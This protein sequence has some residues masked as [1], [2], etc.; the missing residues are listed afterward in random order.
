[1]KAWYSVATNSLEELNNSMP[2]TIADL[3][4]QTEMQRILTLIYDVGVQVC[5]CV[6]NGKYLSYLCQTII[7]LILLKLLT[8]PP[9][10]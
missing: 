7:K 6:F 1:M 2:R 5:S 4:K 3:I 10:M 9:D 8:L